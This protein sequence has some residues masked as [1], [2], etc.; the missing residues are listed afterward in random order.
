MELVPDLTTDAFIRAL[1]RFIGRRGT[2]SLI[3]SDNAKNFTSAYRV[4]LAL[5]KNMEVQGFL[6]SKKIKWKFILQKSPSHCRF[7]ERMV[8]SVK[9]NLRKTLKNAQLNYEEL[10]TVL[11]EVEAVINSRPLTYLYSDNVN[12]A[13]TPVHLIYGKRLLTLPDSIVY[14]QE[15]EDTPE[16]LN[17][18]MKYL[19]TLQN[20]FCQ[21]WQSE[22]LSELR[23]QHKERNNKGSKSMNREIQEGELVT[24]QED[25]LPKG[26]W[27]MG[28][29]EQLLRSQDGVIRGAEVKVVTRN[30]KTSHLRRPVT[31]LCP[32]EVRHAHLL[33]VKISESCILSIQS[34]AGSKFC[35]INF[36]SQLPACNL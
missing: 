12:Q 3:V 36:F 13:L 25:S 27:R 22:Y 10:I 16:L 5:F 32:L 7:Y 31:K 8:Q 14:P 4:L 1:D 35:V 33:A 9:R 30:G 17:K 2:P 11:T 21:K 24:I 15:E 6:N 19:I 26:Q 34:F 29:V 23:E 18:R 20:K 28:L